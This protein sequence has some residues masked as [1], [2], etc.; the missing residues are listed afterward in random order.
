MQLE[1]DVA[2]EEDCATPSDSTGRRAEEGEHSTKE[3]E[4]KLEDMVPRPELTR[5]AGMVWRGR[6]AQSAWLTKRKKTEQAMLVLRRRQAEV[7]TR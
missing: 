1:V 4:E 3:I 7:S 5:G 6:A 2:K